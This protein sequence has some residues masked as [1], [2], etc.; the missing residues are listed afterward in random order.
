MPGKEFDRKINFSRRV[1][2][3]GALAI[4]FLFSIV[5]VYLILN[6]QSTIAG[7]DQAARQLARTL[8]AGVSATIQSAEVVLDFAE[9]EVIER[10]ALGVLSTVDL[11]TKFAEVA[12][13]WSFIH[14]VSFINAR[15]ILQ[16]AAVRDA[17]RVMRAAESL[18]KIDLR[19]QESFSIHLGAKQGEDKLFLSEVREGYATGTP[20]LVISKGVWARDGRLLGV[21]VV[22]IRQDALASLI[23]TAMP[24]T[25]GAI[26]LFRIDGT[27]LW[28][29]PGV[30]LKVGHAYKQSRMFRIAVHEA[31][32]GSY[33]APAMED[34]FA[35]LLAYRVAPRYPLVLVVSTPLSEILSGWRQSALAFSIAG[36]LSTLVIAA[37]T[38]SLARRLRAMRA[39]QI[40]LRESEARLRDML[41]CSSDYMWE[42]DANE[43][44]V[45][46]VGA[47]A[48]N[49]PSH[50]GSHGT[51][52]AFS[53]NEPSDIEVLLEHLKARK[54]YRNLTIPVKGRNGER[55]W[56]RNSANPKFDENGEFQGYRG[57]GTDIT[58]V[59]KQRDIIESQRKTEA[60]GRFASGLA[61]EINN[62]LQPILIYSGFGVSDQAQD[63]RG[64]YFSKI[65]RAAENASNIVRN[66][67]SFTRHAPPRTEAI[68]L[69]GQVNDT[70]E[71]FAARIPKGINLIVDQNSLGH[72]VDVDRTG[73]AQ[74]L[75]NLLT[76]AVE[77][78]TVPP[79]S[80]GEIRILA[81]ELTLPAS[82]EGR[83][84]VKPGRYICLSV[85]DNGPG[86]PPDILKSIFDPFFTTKSQ[87][88]GTGLGLS[89]VASLVKSW[90]GAVTVSSL[91]HASTEFRLYLPV[92]AR[93]LQAA[94]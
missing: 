36:I 39:A 74:V 71:V 87:G 80:G 48:Q 1:A 68:D 8:E 29:T 62:L 77:A 46:L 61:H 64:V 30:E 55:R 65:R 26:S 78:M 59:R 34:G 2:L 10:E 67:L 15:G 7:A 23:Q 91:P 81:R 17:E 70:L 35:R 75:T 60:L 20:I 27:L 42:T 94:Q 72:W 18:N 21:A 53:T 6:R 31:A 19:A 9:A 88:Q 63:E 28:A 54:A 14:S 45:S 33:E 5:T 3:L 57:I 40:A 38:V 32:E 25:D 82:E 66:A 47:G 93:R 12:Q 86:I 83:V 24:I 84:D 73:L 79:N 13:S 90:S 92:G 22:A 37:L 11:S 58:E 43:R 56:V 89:V 4:I 69:S 50:L 51:D 52:V 41:E 44:V 85:A 16:H 76:N 49:Y